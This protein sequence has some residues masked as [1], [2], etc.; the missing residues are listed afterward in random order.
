MK[1]AIIAGTFFPHQGG[2][3]V[4]IHNLANKLVERGNKVD[5][6]VFKK[7]NLT[8]NLYN[9]I[10]LNYFY[11]SFLYIT[12]YFLNFNLKPIL[13]LFKFIDL[14][15]EVYHFSFLN[16][17]S[18]IL[19]EYLKIFKKKILVTFH[20]A[21]IQVNK[22]INYGFRI[23]Q[24]FNTYLLKNVKKIDAFQCISELIYKDLLKLGVNKKKI[25]KISNSIYLKKFK[26]KKNVQSSNECLKLITVGRYAKYKKGYDLIPILGKK[27]I[28]S[29][30]NFKWKII[31]ENSDYIYHDE[32]VSKNKK[33][34][35]AIPN[36]QNKSEKYF[37][38]KKLITHYS[39]SHLYIN[40]ARIESFGLTFIEALAS[41]TPIVSLG[42]TGI[43]KIFKNDNVSFFV[44]N[45][46]D[47]TKILKR[48]QSNPK[49]LSNIQKKTYQSIKQF[50]LDD[51][52]E[53]ITIF[54]SKFINY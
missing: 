50:N 42:S 28:S 2:V 23:N 4:E 38:P 52:V 47:I 21:D 46:N 3:Q 30:I 13:H 17:K 45:I 25:I 31:G 1:I 19:I 6:F 51:N 5:V 16:F 35:I 49:L 40:L 10:K 9:I 7:V 27:L 39:G 11:L 53:Q 41:K 37:P 29:K 24:K 14:N 48:I 54:Y 36:I 33:K 43:N 18:L 22:K 26:L 12:K 44:K 8:N 15:Y 32:F 20:G 34:F